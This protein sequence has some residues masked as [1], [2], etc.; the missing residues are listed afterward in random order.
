MKTPKTPI[1]ERKR[2]RILLDPIYVQ[3]ANLT[4]SSTYHKYVSLTREL[5]SRG[6]FVYW[7]LPDAE[8]TPKEIENHP[9]VG[10]IRSSYIQDQFVIDGLFTDRFFNLFNRV[11]GEYH[12]DVLC[13]SR[14]SLVAYYKRVLDPPRFH[15]TTG[16]FT[17]KGYGLPIVLIEE[18]PQT[19]ERQHSSRSY[20]INQVMGYLCADRTIF[21]SDHNR[22]EVVREMMDFVTIK[23]TRR[24]LDSVRIIPSGIETAELDKLYEP[25]RWRVETGFNV[26]SVGRLFGVSYIEYLPWFDTLYKAGYS[27]STFTV[28]L[29][30]ALS[31]PMRAKLEKIGFDLGNFGHQFKLYENNPRSNFLRMLR[32]FHCAV[33]PVSHLDHPTGIFEALYLGV[34]CVLPISD[35]QQTFFKDY[36]FV[37]DPKDRAAYLATLL[38]IRDNPEQAREQILPWREIIREKYDAPHNI[39]RLSDEIEAVARD[40]IRRFRTSSGVINLAKTL[41]GESYSWADVVA[42]LQRSGRMGVSIGDMG[43][44]TT[45]TYARGAIHHAMH[46]A[47]YID[48]CDG[49]QDRYVRADVWEREQATTNVRA[50]VRIRPKPVPGGHSHGPKTSGSSSAPSAGDP[51]PTAPTT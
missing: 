36:P 3:A 1:P 14:N 26:I 23:E 42:H 48:P 43:I 37:I 40:F 34:P 47:G 50:P 27:D 4:S 39:R 21:L 30:G 6:H 35:F 5:V 20:W 25:D 9:Q 10:I 17:D 29:S 32:K 38:H 49:P 41:R 33:V 11:A 13:T 24:F 15:D 18:F 46:V 51:R 7:M 45:F 12:I 8:Y 16:D 28:S 19:R 44:R 22:E 2:L 31:G